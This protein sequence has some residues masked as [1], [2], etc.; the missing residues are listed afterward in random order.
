[1]SRHVRI[2]FKLSK[3]C[4][5]NIAAN[6]ITYNVI[7]NNICNNNNNPC[8][9]AWVNNDSYNNNNLAYLDIPI[10]IFT[11]IIITLSIYFSYPGLCYYI[12]IITYNVTKRATVW[13][14]HHF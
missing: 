9:K 2:V 1:M 3:T 8:M 14:E 6:Y 7:D 5:L 12:I 10:A 11:V 13:S 4:V